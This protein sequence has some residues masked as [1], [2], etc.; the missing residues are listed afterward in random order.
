MSRAIQ[1]QSYGGP[2][3]F[4]PHDVHVGEPGP[5][6]VRLS[7]KAIGIN[8]IDIYQRT[9]LYKLPALPAVPVSSPA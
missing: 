6:E 2:E 3:V 1:I 7:Q 8:Y 5:G 4:S 9:G